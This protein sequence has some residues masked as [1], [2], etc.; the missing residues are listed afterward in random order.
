ML[1]PTATPI[2]RAGKQKVSIRKAVTAAHA[3]WWTYR[4]VN[5]V[6]HGD[7]DG[8][9]VFSSIADNGEL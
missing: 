6:V 3:Q 7:R 2:Y 8:R 4:E 5:L 1:E 9:D